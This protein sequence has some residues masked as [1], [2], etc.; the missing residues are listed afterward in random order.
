MS[1]P[2]TLSVYGVSGGGNADPEYGIHVY[3]TPETITVL[4]MPNTGYIFSKWIKDHGASTVTDNP[5]TLIMDSNK[6]IEPVFT[7]TSTPSPY[8]YPRIKMDEAYLVSGET[9]TIQINT[10]GYGV[11][12]PPPGIVNIPPKTILRIIAYA[13][14][15]SSLDHWQ[16]G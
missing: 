1:S 15:G 2:Y 14:T 11:T 12:S 7:L 5:I 16:F 10:E 4:A 6:S 13:D 8:E 3:P 9:G